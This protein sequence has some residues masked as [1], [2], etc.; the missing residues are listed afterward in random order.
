[1]R[2]VHRICT[3]P[4]SY[5]SGA[6]GSRCL[7][8][9]LVSESGHSMTHLGSC[10]EIVRLRRRVVGGRRNHSGDRLWLGRCLG[11]ASSAFLPVWHGSG[12]ASAKRLSPSLARAGSTIDDTICVPIGLCGGS[13]KEMHTF[14]VI[15]SQCHLLDGTPCLDLS[16]DRLRTYYIEPAPPK[17]MLSLIKK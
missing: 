10:S 14:G 11:T 15:R 17:Y 16:L 12:P 6:C 8:H 2:P 1:M 4:Q 13:T 5:F 3:P 7:L 9:A